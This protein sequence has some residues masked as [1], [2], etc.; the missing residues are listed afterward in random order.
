VRSGSRTVVLAANSLWYITNFRTGLI[1]ALVEAGYRPIVA[2]PPD[3]VHE[4]RLAEL[5]CGFEPVTIDRKGLNPLAELSLLLR[6]RRILRRLKPFAYIG[7]TIK[8]NIYGAL[9]APKLGVPVI[10]NVS[11]LGTAFIRPGPL[12]YIATTLY[13]VA[14]RRV[15]VFFE[16]PDD[17]Q[18]FIDRKILRAAQTRLVPGSGIDLEWF[19]VAP[20]PVGP[21]KFLLIARL[22]GDKGVREFVEAARAARRR[23]PGARFRILG[24]L[25][26]GNRTSIAPAELKAWLDEGVIEH[27]GETEDVRPFIAD[28]TAVVLPSYREGLPRSLLEGGAMGRPLIATDVPGCREVIDDS[29]NGFLC[30]PRDAASLAGTMERLAG[31]PADRRAAMGA[32]ARRKVQEQFSEALVVRAYLDALAALHSG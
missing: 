29:V 27:L 24:E 13:R 22:I 15:T 28:A 30:A 18:L 9:A 25:D 20:L 26:E 8:P 14:F 16:N 23:V 32:A 17:R 3:A 11:G 19:A 1:R 31:L 4:R 6:Y 5:G 2:G 12:Q 21:P 7:F 10:A